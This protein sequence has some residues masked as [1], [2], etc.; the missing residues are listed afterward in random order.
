VTK[1]RLYGTAEIADRLGVSRQRAY[2]ISR[3]KDFPDPYE[4]LEMGSVWLREDVERWIAAHR[5]ELNEP[6]DA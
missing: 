2:I 1:G 3:T 6:D 4:T 5:P